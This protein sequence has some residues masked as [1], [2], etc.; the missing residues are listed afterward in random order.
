MAVRMCIHATPAQNGRPDYAVERVRQKKIAHYA[1]VL[2]PANTFRFTMVENFMGSGSVA[3]VF[4]TIGCLGAFLMMVLSPMFHAHAETAGA[5][6]TLVVIVK[7]S[8]SLALVNP[9]SATVIANIPENAPAK[10]TGHEVAT[11]PDGRF[12]YVPIYGNSGVGKPGTDGNNMVVMDLSTHAIV[13]NLDFG[14]PVRP[15]LPVFGKDGMLYVTNELDH[16]VAVVDPNPTAPKVVGTIPTGKAESHM[17]ALSHDGKYG[18]TA[19]VGSGTVSV[20]DIENR[21]LLTVIPVCEEAQRIS[22]STDDSMVFTSDQKKPELVVIDTASRKV[23][24]R[25]ALPGIG[26]GSAPSTDGHWLFVTLPDVNRVAVVDLK[27]MKVAHTIDVGASPQ[28]VVIHPG[29]KTA[30]VSC[31]SAGEVDELDLATWT[32]KRKIDTG[33]GTDG[34]AWARGQ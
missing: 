9:T 20:L 1:T 29:G 30:Y 11:S 26:Y 6:G 34:M 7:S 22:V 3:K 18:Y 14:H 5:A 31:M 4:G 24:A 16:A 12:A 23:K 33:K 19:N 10:D 25:I 15:H 28:V 2:R 27:A 8:K 13:G 21:K 32:V 17:L